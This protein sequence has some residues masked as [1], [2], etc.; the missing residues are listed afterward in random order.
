[1]KNDSEEKDASADTYRI[2]YLFH[3]HLD[4]NR[5]PKLC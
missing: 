3:P 4:W 2:N 5:S 1:M